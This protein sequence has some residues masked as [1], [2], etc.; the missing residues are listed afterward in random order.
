MTEKK[1]TSLRVP[2]DKKLKLERLAIEISYKVG[3]PIKW[4][5]LAFYMF[6]NYAN[7]AAQDLKNKKE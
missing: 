1:Y 6:D 5:D 3:K 2:E 7:D 4:T